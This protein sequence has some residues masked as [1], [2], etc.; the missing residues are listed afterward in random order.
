MSTDD[1]DHTT[2]DRQKGD[3][4]TTTPDRMPW[5]GPTD[6][7]Q[8]A[9][10]PATGFASSV[11]DPLTGERSEEYPPRG[12]DELIR[13][14]SRDVFVRQAQELERAHV[15]SALDGLSGDSAALAA[16]TRRT[17]DL[18][19]DVIRSRAAARAEH[20]PDDVRDESDLR[21][22]L[23]GAADDAEVLERIAAVFVDGG[24]LATTIAGDLVAELPERRGKPVR[25]V[26]VGDGQGSR[27][28]VTTAQPTKPFAELEVIVDVLGTWQGAAGAGLGEV[29]GPVAYAQ[30]VRAGMT[31]LLGI[32]SSPGVKTTALDALRVKLGDAG[33]DALAKR[34]R[35][36]YGRKDHGE[37]TAKLSREAIDEEASE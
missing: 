19:L 4:V 33:E 8:G 9:G 31:A 29:E 20:R 12:I 6:E 25:T 22:E 30:G 23:V 11:V 15:A 21:A 27:L 28:T 37:P 14:T 35:A 13:D 36:A 2:H 24:K 10:H 26:H 5:G 1:T 32:L 7:G 17:R 34:L 3:T 18:V 16:F